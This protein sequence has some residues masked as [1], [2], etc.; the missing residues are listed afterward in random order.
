MRGIFSGSAGVFLRREGRLRKNPQSRSIRHP[1]YILLI[2]IL[3]IGV[4]VSAAVSSL[5]L[6]GISSNKSS[7]SVQQSSQA[8]A[9]TQGCGEEALLKLKQSLWYEG[10]ETIPSSVGTCT[11]LTIGGSGNSD[12][13]ICLEGVVGEVVRRVEI[14]V[15]KVL[16]EMKITSWREV[17]VFTSCT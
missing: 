15:Q 13:L 5:L 8:L 7:F 17:T 2:T 6:L 10:N 11:I 3:V 16:P 4:I 1:G 9:I 14:I 12:R